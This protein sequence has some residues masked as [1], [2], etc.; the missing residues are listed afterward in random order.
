MAQYAAGG[1][2]PAKSSAKEPRETGPHVADSVLAA[3]AHHARTVSFRSVMKARKASLFGRQGVGCG[4]GDTATSVAADVAEMAW[5]TLD[6]V[7][8]TVELRCPVR[9]LQDVPLFMRSAVRMATAPSR[10]RD[11]TIGP[12]TPTHGRDELVS[13]A[14]AFQLGEW[15]WLLASASR[16]SAAERVSPAANMGCVGRPWRAWLATLHTSFREREM[17]PALTPPA[18]ASPGR[19]PV[20]GLPRFFPMQR[21][22]MQVA[23]KRRL[24]LPLPHHG[25]VLWPPA[26][27]CGACSGEDIASSI[28][29]IGLAGALVADN[30]PDCIVV[31]AGVWQDVGPSGGRFG[32]GAARESQELQFLE[33]PSFSFK[34]V[35][36]VGFDEVGVTNGTPEP[37]AHAEFASTPAPLSNSPVTTRISGA[38]RT[39]TVVED[40]ALRPSPALDVQR[41]DAFIGPRAARL[42]MQ[43]FMARWDKAFGGKTKLNGILS[44]NDPCHAAPPVYLCGKQQARQV[45]EQVMRTSTSAL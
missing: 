21:P 9:T 43:E 5:A 19:M 3:T 24:R 41:K 1:R 25:R 40:A 35:C 26:Q 28:P 31:S 33:Q 15:V 10:I 30:G 27:G 16:F 20:C 11:S 38:A 4:S 37:R 23:M 32:A 39:G 2:S 13:R 45:Q 34:A 44:E 14:A 12:T 6:A 8:V 7:D 29:G 36:C 42:A 17:L 18:R 22:P